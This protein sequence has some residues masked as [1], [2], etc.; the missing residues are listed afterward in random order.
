MAQEANGLVITDQEGVVVYVNPMAERIFYREARRF[1]GK[2]FGYRI[3][4][5]ETIVIDIFSPDG[6][7]Y[8]AELSVDA[9]EWDGKPAYIIELKRVDD[10]LNQKIKA[11]LQK[12]NHRFLALINAAPLAIVTLNNDG[13]VIF[14]SRSAEKMFGWSSHEVLGK[15]PL[16]LSGDGNNDFLRWCDQALDENAPHETELLGQRRRDGS[17]IDLRI[18]AANLEDGDGFMGSLMAVIADV[19]EHK[20][21]EARMQ[22]LA[23]HDGL[24][25]LP[26]RILLCDRISQALFKIFREG[27]E[28]AAVLVIGLNNFDLVL[29][30][31]GFVAGDR[32]LNELAQRLGGL[33][34]QS[35]TLARYGQDTFAVVLPALEREQD[36]AKVAEKILDIFV[37]PFF[38]DELEIFLSASVGIAMSSSD[39]ESAE[40]LLRNADTAMRRAHMDNRRG[41]HFYTHG[42][43]ELAAKRLVLVRG[44][45]HSLERKELCLYYQPVVKLATGQI[46]GVEALLRWRHPELGLI[47]PGDFIPIAEEEGLIVPIGEWVLR[48]GCA[49]IRRWEEQGL[50]RLRLAVNLSARQF[51][52]V[53]LPQHIASI[54][55]ETGMPAECLEIELTESMLASNVEDAV[56][57]MKQLKS[58]G[59]CLS[60]DDFGTGYSSLSY[61][62]RFPLDVLKIDRSFVSEIPFNADDIQI[63]STIVA[64]AHGFNLRVIAEGAETQA[65]IDFLTKLHCD[66]VQGFYYSK[67]LPPA[68][69]VDF[70]MVKQ[71]GKDSLAAA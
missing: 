21:V 35:D 63:C 6:T 58:I 49:Q 23:T 45:R 9:G 65:Q 44:L 55:A 13:T 1:V 16:I 64:M 34:R 66:E 12:S 18:W 5:G 53:D 56:S 48:E 3:V 29:Q 46:V 20:R 47:P 60:I 61:L 59:V 62:K 7:P 4:E 27:S 70:L 26:N 69:L 11:S 37:A 33:V 31:L 51:S 24:T 38:I 52:E 57:M 40:V 50:G 30:S 17:L 22:R 28:M 71:C 42:M 68:E 39:G 10:W 15:A 67:P 19:T 2:P 41:F 25:G 36:A 8:Q 43:N 54:L 14:W 32:L